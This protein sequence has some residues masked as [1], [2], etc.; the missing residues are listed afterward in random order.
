MCNKILPINTFNSNFSSYKYKILF[1]S[2]NY[3]YKACNPTIL[4]LSI[5]LKKKDNLRI[6]HVPIVLKF[7]SLK[8]L[9]PSGSV[10]GL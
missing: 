10:P 1:L 5:N 8:L 4:N 7:V 9:E 6:V 2:M 3:V